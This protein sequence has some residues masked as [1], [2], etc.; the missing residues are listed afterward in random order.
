M[1]ETATKTAGT[2][3]AARQ[4]ILIDLGKKKRKSVK[5]LRRG[6]GPLMRAVSDA[7]SELQSSG[8]VDGAGQD[9]VVII[10]EKRKRRGG[11]TW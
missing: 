8:S 7:I 3:A 11:W 4:P 6:S 9:V 2:G 10:R 1:A 5:K